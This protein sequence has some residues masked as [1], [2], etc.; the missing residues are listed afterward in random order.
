MPIHKMIQEGVGD[1]LGNGIIMPVPNSQQGLRA[2]SQQ[3]EESD[4]EHNSVNEDVS[5]SPINNL[6]RQVRDDFEQA[7]SQLAADKGLASRNKDQQEQAYV[8]VP[9]DDQDLHN[10]QM[11]TDFYGKEAAQMSR[12]SSSE[13]PRTSTISPLQTAGGASVMLMDSVPE[14]SSTEKNAI[15]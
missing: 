15:T 12:Q 14:P 13:S 3:L 6:E 8:Y 5:P 2:Q 1:W 9:P 4:H 7:V 10:E 11:E